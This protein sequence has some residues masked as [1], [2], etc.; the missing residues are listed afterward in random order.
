MKI[1]QAY[2][3]NSF[4]IPNITFSNQVTPKGTP[5]RQSIK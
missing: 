5:S 3:L 4:R 2:T 1:N